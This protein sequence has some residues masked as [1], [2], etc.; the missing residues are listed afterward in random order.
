MLSFLYSK[1]KPELRAA[2]FRQVS[3]LATLTG[4][5]FVTILRSL[6]EQGLIDPDDMVIEECLHCLTNLLRR[7]L[8]SAPIAVSFLTRALALTA[9]PCLRIR[10]GSVAY[11]TSFAR[12]AVNFAEK[13][14]SRVLTE[15]EDTVP[16][17]HHFW[18]GIC[19]PAS[20]YARLVNI[21][22]KKTIFR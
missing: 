3:P 15:D 22:V 7:R 6:L 5:Q 20:V 19:S 18:P 8:L 2:F 12:L 1:C 21:E 9:H 14:Q 11:I 16:M 4:A 17:V 13:S 10:Q